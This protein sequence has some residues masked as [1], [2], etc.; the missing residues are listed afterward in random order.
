MTFKNLL[1]ATLLVAVCIAWL[2]IA[3]LRPQP[4]QTQLGVVFPPDLNQIQV[5]SR[6]ADA[7]GRL[8]REGAWPFIAV[9]AVDGPDIT[10]RLRDAGALFTVNP[11]VL[12]S[13]LTRPA[14][15]STLSKAN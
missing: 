7:G 13:C 10:A 15:A 11:L 5:L 6:I 8:V 2:A 12:G 4:G 9:V 14:V 3:S 1:P